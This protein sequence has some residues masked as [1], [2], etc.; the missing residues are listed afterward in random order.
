[1]TEV[2]RWTAPTALRKPP[3]HPVVLVGLLPSEG[4]LGLRELAERW[5]DRAVP[6]APLVGRTIAYD[7]H[8]GVPYEHRP[9]GEVIAALTTD[10]NGVVSARPQDY[11]PG[12][13]ARLPRLDPAIAVGARAMPWRRARLWISPPGAITPLHQEV[14]HNLLAQLEGEKEVTLFS[15]W[16]RAAMYSHPPWSRMPHVSRVAAHAPD[17]VKHPRFTRA[18]P[19]RTRLEA[20]DVLYI[21][22]LWW[23][24]VRAIDASLSYNLW[25][26]GGLVAAAAA[27]LERYKALRSLRI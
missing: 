11:L 6:V 20:G 17:L 26:A 21:P 13:E 9:L 7:A 19:Q 3:R 8:A 1:M 14:T 5:G 25:F 24:W 12:I 16:D 2:L 27:A 15:P 4:R 22:P 23:H 18:R 10:A